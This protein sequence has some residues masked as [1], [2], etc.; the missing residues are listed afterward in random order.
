[1]ERHYGMDWLRIGAFALLIFYHIGMVFVPWGFHIKTA[2]PMDWV[3]IP[4]L[5]TNP[6][7]LTLL[8]VVSGYASR[9]LL[10]KSTGIG[11]FLGNRSSRLLIPLVFGMAVVVPPQTWVELVSK[12]GYDH[13]YLWFLAHDYFRFG[14]LD[15]IVMPTWNHLWFV[16]Y[17]W[18]YT[19]ALSLM[20]LLPGTDR[21]QAAFDRVFG[22]P[23]AVWVPVIFLLVTQFWLF[24]RDDD[25]HDLFGDWLAHLQYFPAFLFGFGLA[26]SRVAKLGLSRWWAVAAAIAIACYAVMA[27]LLVA[28]P[29]F[30]FPS[31]DVT[32]AFRL[33][34][35]IDS[36]T[37]IAAL[38][39]VAERFLNR[40]H[41]WRATLAEATFSF[42]IIHQTVIVLVEFWVKPLGI[43]AAGEFAILVPA[44][45]AG[46]WAFYLIGREIDPLRPLIGLKAR[47]KA[48]K[49]AVSGD[50]IEA[51]RARPDVA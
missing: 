33:A 18:A 17:L 27:G 46:C 43:G 21:L 4:M 29:D 5:L 16:A 24:H 7:R 3:E 50:W 36:W 22:G 39:G 25:T 45:I 49:P 13:S 1:M 30:S 42:Y 41:R 31:H 20:M 34:R 12:Y 9:A 48:A 15:G 23:R 26:G 8:F 44:T 2:Q 6:W 40:D 32:I 11:G 14:K 28:Y 35:E 47:G 51:V 37:A 19:L 10:T 38:I